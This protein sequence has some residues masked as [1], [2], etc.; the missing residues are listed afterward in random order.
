MINR[1]LKLILNKE[2]K[3]TQQDR[4]KMRSNKKKGTSKKLDN[5]VPSLIAS[6]D[7]Q[8]LSLLV[9]YPESVTNLDNV[10]Y[11][12]DVPIVDASILYD[13]ILESLTYSMSDIVMMLTH[14]RCLNIAEI[15]TIQKI[16][17]WALT[18]SL[19]YVGALDHESLP[20]C[21]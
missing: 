13:L 8:N 4:Y 1:Q 12:N 20:S 7:E 3:T 17:I 6:A 16:C 15:E 11:K 2:Q 5:I 19:G 9:H 14:K 18:S 10:V 21:H